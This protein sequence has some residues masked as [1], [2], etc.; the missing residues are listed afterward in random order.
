MSARIRASIVIALSFAASTSNARDLLVASRFTDAVLRYDAAGNFLGNAA[1]GG[2][3]DNPVGITLAADG[4][5]V[6][7]SANNDQV[8]RYDPSTGAFLGVVASGGL[9]SGARHLNYGPDGALYVLSA[10]TNQVLRLD[11]ATGTFVTFATTTDLNGPTGFT[12][13]PDG[14]L[15]V[16][17]VLNNRVLR[18]DGKTGA[19]LGIFATT[20]LNGPHDLAFGPDGRLW[21]SNAFGPV[22]KIVRFDATTGAIV[23]VI[24]K[25]AA[26]VNPLGLCFD[27]DGSLLVANQGGDEVRR[28]DSTTGALLGVAVAPGAGGLDGPLFLTKMRGATSITQDVPMPAGVNH[29]AFFS[30]EGARPGG[31]AALVVGATPGA[32]PVPS[33]PGL[34]LGMLDPVVLALA[35]CDESGTL[36]RRFF[37][38]PIAQGFTFQLQAVDVAACA[39]SATIAHVF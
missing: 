14:N 7:A 38:P 22:N 15:Y 16:G 20:K 18:F 30:L 25:D 17:S 39:G 33:C 11:A 21:V 29:D 4:S 8:L 19:Y 37:V 34:V 28:Y 10:N 32:L 5:L 1:I 23:D 6:V 3:L 9:L 2:G 12:F 24:V 26:L 35:P 27:V 31:L 36:V 13:G